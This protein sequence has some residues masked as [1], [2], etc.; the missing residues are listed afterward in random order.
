MRGSVDGAFCTWQATAGG[1]RKLLEEGY[2]HG[3]EI[4]PWLFQDLIDCGDLYTG[5]SGLT[6]RARGGNR[7]KAANSINRP[8]RLKAQAEAEESSGC[9][10]IVV[11]IVII[12]IF[13]SC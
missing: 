6:E 9:A 1:T 11:V 12:I 5:N 2:R 3:D 8:K 10:T 7:S 13:F 4:D